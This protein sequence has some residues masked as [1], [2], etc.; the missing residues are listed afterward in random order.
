MRWLFNLQETHLQ[1]TG[2]LQFDGSSG[3]GLK[4]ALVQDGYKLWANRMDFLVM[5]FK[6][7]GGATAAEKKRA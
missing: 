4:F 6:G 3:D 2:D 5:Q 1:I 7:G